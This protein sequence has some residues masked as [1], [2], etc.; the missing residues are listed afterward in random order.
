MFGQIPLKH[1]RVR[2]GQCV[3]AVD[4]TVI[5]YKHTVQ[6]NIHLLSLQYIF[7]KDFNCT[8]YVFSHTHPLPG[9]LWSIP[10]S[11]WYSTLHASFFIGFSNLH[12]T[13]YKSL[14]RF[15]NSTVFMQLINFLP[16]IS[17]RIF[18]HSQFVSFSL[19]LYIS[20]HFKSTWVSFPSSL[21]RRHAIVYVQCEWCISLAWWTMF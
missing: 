2:M 1:I 6:S 7:P 10:F 17:S 3:M 20:L 14:P 5:I 19:H 15:L 4:R 21:H 8:H 18:K 9:T 12:F 16:A 11:L 13:F